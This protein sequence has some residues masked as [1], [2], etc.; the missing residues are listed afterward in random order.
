MVVEDVSF[1]VASDVVEKRSPKNSNGVP[2][3]K[4]G[5]EI[6]QVDYSNN[7]HISCFNIL[8]CFFGYN[9]DI[10][11]MRSFLEKDRMQ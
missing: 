6:T 7:V 2:L 9:S 1:D 8:P 11:C 3:E 4:D 10:Y 5:I